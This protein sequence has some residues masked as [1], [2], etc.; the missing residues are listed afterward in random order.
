MAKRHWSIKYIRAVG[1]WEDFLAWKKR[2]M[3]K[4]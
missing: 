1:L 3:V 4:K 2:E